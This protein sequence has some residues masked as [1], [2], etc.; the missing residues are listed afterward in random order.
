MLSCSMQE[1]WWTNGMSVYSGHV[2]G[3]YYSRLHDR[4][5]YVLHTERA[6]YSRGLLV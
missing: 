6:D 5:I 3:L 2:R 1:L 4:N